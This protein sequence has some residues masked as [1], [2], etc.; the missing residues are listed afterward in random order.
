VAKVLEERVKGLEFKAI[1]GEGHLTL[2]FEVLDE[3][4]EKVNVESN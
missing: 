4:I 1:D 2:V 3:V